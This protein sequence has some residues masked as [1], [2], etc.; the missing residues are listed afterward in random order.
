VGEGV[1]RG[2]ERELAGG[3]RGSEQGVGEG[4]S[5]GWERE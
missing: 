1:S 3:G 4:V 5:R 2:W